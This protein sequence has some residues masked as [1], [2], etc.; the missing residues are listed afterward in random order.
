MTEAPS[1]L[2]GQQ[3]LGGTCGRA[4]HAW[5]FPAW[6]PPE[7]MMLSAAT[8]AVDPVRAYRSA[9]CCRMGGA[10]C[11]RQHRVAAVLRALKPRGRQ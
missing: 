7:T 4:K 2:L 6:V 5:T 1:H 3:P 10:R 8:T 9:A 11:G